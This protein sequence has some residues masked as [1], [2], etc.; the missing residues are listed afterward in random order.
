MKKNKFSGVSHHDIHWE[1]D[2]PVAVTLMLG[3]TAE[4]LVDLPEQTVTV[5]KGEIK[6][7]K[8]SWCLHIGDF[9]A[10][11]AL[12][13]RTEKQRQKTTPVGDQS[14]EFGVRPDPSNI[15]WG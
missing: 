10:R 11:Q 1:N 13:K 14:I 6:A 2:V 3:D 4:V 15:W 9:L 12:L 8:S 5:G 7:K